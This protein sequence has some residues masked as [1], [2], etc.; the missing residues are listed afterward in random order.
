MFYTIHD[1]NL[2]SRCDRSPAYNTSG[3]TR[4]RVLLTTVTV[5]SFRKRFGLPQVE[6]VLPP[7][8]DCRNKVGY[9]MYV[10][11]GAMFWCDNRNLSLNV[12][13][14]IEIT[15][16]FK[17]KHTCLRFTQPPWQHSEVSEKH[18]VPG[19]AYD[20]WSQMLHWHHLPC[21]K[22][23]PT[24][25]PPVTDEES[26]H[27]ASFPH[28][29]LHGDDVHRHLRRLASIQELFQSRCRAPPTHVM[30][31]SIFYPWKMILQHIVQDPPKK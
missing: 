2:L 18:Q 9:L 5:E 20:R 31:C 19:G 24:Y 28:Y 25:T 26:K 22:G 27:A 7:K 6:H 29:F 14:A 1:L 8:I 17:R 11:G 13:K 12:N 16:V 3:K 30:V 21:Q 23:I 15:V 10:V 4:S